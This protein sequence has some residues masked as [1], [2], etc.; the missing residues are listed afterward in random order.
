M[1]RTILLARLTDGR[2]VQVGRA[3]P[4]YATAYDRFEQSDSEIS[5]FQRVNGRMRFGGGPRKTHFIDG[6][7]V[8]FYRLR[9]IV[10]DNIEAE[11]GH[12]ST[13]PMSAVRLTNNQRSTTSMTSKTPSGIKRPETPDFKT[14][15]RAR[16]NAKSLNVTNGRGYRAL[17]TAKGD[18][19]TV[20][21]R[22]AVAANKQRRNREI[23]R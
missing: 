21:F 16:A 10:G 14:W 17:K 2:H 19:Y 3:H 12:V 20:I 13:F 5:G 9:E 11:F 1:A 8:S 22:P 18:G 6:V 23:V 7:Q 15:D 4:D